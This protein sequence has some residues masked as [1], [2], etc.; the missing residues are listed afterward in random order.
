[1]PWTG[2]ST[3]GALDAIVI[4]AQ[5]KKGRPGVL[6]QVIATPEKREELVARD[7]PRNHHA[8]RAL[9]SAERRVQPREWV[10]VQTT[11]GMVRMKDGAHRFRARI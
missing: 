6:L 4:P 7:V 9:L 3:P 2:C 10:E 8:R 5:M 1:M 11:H